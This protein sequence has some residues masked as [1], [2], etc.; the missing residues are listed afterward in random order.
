MP[1]SLIIMLALPLNHIGGS[2]NARCHN[3]SLPSHAPGV[4]NTQPLSVECTRT[5]LEGHVFCHTSLRMSL[6]L[7]AG[8]LHRFYVAAITGPKLSSPAGHQYRLINAVSRVMKSVHQLLGNGVQ[9][10]VRTRERP[11]STP[12][13]WFCHKCN[14]GPYTI[15]AQPSCTN[16]I[17]GRQCDHR[18]CDY[19]R[20]E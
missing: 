9:L 11:T 20:K 12:T 6:N 3:V 18:K 17:N 7:P 10:R 5:V 13:R 2:R 19:C 4:G 8:P 15:A 1:L 14:T 16:V